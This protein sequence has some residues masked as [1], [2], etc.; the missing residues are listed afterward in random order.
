M[1]LLMKA[2]KECGYHAFNVGINDLAYGIENLQSQAEE[3]DFPFLSANIADSTGNLL[4][5]PYTILKHHGQRIGIVGVASSSPGA[6]HLQYGDVLEAA[7]QMREEIKDQADYM[8]LLAS[9]WN[10]DAEHLKKQLE[11]YDLLIRSHTP[12]MSRRPDQIADGYYLQTG[13]Q[14]RYIHLLEI[15]GYEA[16]QPLVD[17]TSEKQRLRFIEL[18]LD[19]LQKQAGDKS[20]EEAYQGNKAT[21]KFIEK[22]REQR[23][24]LRNEV[25][26]T[27]HYFALTVQSLSPQIQGD[28][29]WIEAVERFNRYVSE[30]TAAR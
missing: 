17:L 1:S 30:V 10:S 4:F 20:L 13:D 27:Q 22:L 9:V 25:S 23:K 3:A 8:I 29:K 2:Y 26:G 19:R 21:L 24:Q 6:P 18:R 16:D 11:G 12:R 28:Q 14:G 15:E 5:E 7:K